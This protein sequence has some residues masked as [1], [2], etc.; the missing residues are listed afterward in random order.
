[1]GRRYYYRSFGDEAFDD[2]SRAAAT[3]RRITAASEER[4]RQKYYDSISDRLDA[5]PELDIQELLSA[6]IENGKKD[7][8]RLLARG[9]LAFLAAWLLNLPITAA[10]AL[11]SSGGFFN[12]ALLV[13]IGIAQLIS[14][15]AYIFGFVCIIKSSK[16]KNTAKL[17]EELYR[18]NRNS[19]F[20]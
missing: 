2:F 8:S 3:A 13:L 12:I 15:A 16:A 20:M 11:Y 14:A 17:A 5:D 1:M 4:K 10:P 19:R 7:R 18:Q 6:D 9:I